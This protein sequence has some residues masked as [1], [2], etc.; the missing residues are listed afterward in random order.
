MYKVTIVFNEYTHVDGELKKVEFKKTGKCTTF[1]DVATFIACM[2]E[3]FGSI[4]CVVEEV[5]V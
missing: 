3:A 1:D 4:N 2:V 5:R